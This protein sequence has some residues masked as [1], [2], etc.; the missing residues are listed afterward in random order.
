VP[1]AALSKTAVPEAADPEGIERHANGVERYALQGLSVMSG[2]GA[3]GPA[4]NPQNDFSLFC[5]DLPLLLPI[6]R[7]P[8]TRR[9]LRVDRAAL[10][11]YIGRRIH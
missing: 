4:V 2:E 6:L 5:S 1:K 8:R 10:P 9:Q 7:N 3:F 11:L